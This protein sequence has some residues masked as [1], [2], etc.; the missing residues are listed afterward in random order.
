LGFSPWGY[1]GSVTEET[2]MHR[3]PALLRAVSSNKG[4]LERIIREK[5]AYNSV[6]VETTAEWQK[7]RSKDLPGSSQK[8]I[9]L[10]FLVESTEG[11]F[12]CSQREPFMQTGRC[13]D[14]F[15]HMT[16]AFM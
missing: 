10:A 1:C 2:E 7:R 6:C 15:N 11:V 4:C 8:G 12:V 13:F 3:K 5:R 14:P 9:Q 16:L